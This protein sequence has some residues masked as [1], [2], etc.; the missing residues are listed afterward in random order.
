MKTV[1]CLLLAC[2]LCVSLGSGA[3]AGDGVPDTAL[4]LV[5]AMG[6]G[7]NLGNT[8][9]ACDA[10]RGRFSSFPADYEI[11][12]G[13]PVTTPEMLRGL[14]DAGFDTIRIPVAW[15]TNAT[16]LG[17]GDWTI[18]DAYMTRVAQVVGWALDAG[19]YVI[20][21]DHWDGGWWGMFGSDTA[22]TA[23][24]AREAYQ[25]MWQQIAARFRDADRH[26][27][28]ES[29]NEELGDR[30][31][32]DSAL[33]CDDSIRHLL[34]DAR[35][36]E[37]TNEINQLFVDTV[38]AAGGYNADRYLLIAGY[39]TNIAKTC[40]MRFKMPKDT[41]PD[42]LLISVHYYDPWSYC[43][44]TTASGA[45]RWGTRADMEYMKTTLGRMR[46]FSSQGYGVVIG[47]YGALPGSTGKQKDNAV[48]YHRLFL[49]LCEQYNYCGCLW[50]TSGFYNRRALRFHDEAMGALYLSARAEGDPAQAAA[51][52]G[53]D[54]DRLI[55]EAPE[56]FLENAIELDNT[57]CV[58]W[59]MWNSGDWQQSYSVGDT[60]TP[61]SVTPGLKPTDAVIDGPGDYTVA[62]DFT[63]TDRGYSNSTAFS[64]IG[65]RSGEALHPGWAVHIKSFKVNGQDYTL[66]GRPYTTSD[67]GRCTRVNIYNAWVSDIPADA[68]VLYGPNI[69]IKPVIIDLN[70]PVFSHIE[71]IEITFTY[72]EKK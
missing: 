36:Y 1:I 11:L 21:N 27:I 70:D 9:E 71:T 35:R 65:I 58:A 66:K 67:D 7:T 54:A 34:P 45:T 57:T 24:L 3:R 38:R 60:Y 12:W 44:A 62:L 32:E 51:N 50:D 37:L 47:E 63:G 42:R 40:D 17:E 26:L 25:G 52:A 43:G 56:T 69:G 10:N 16:R 4:E 20:L 30:F 55:A 2:C 31:D 33:Y 15:M 6:N 72:A 59:I 39:G 13:Q 23:A 8:F 18:D 68:R 61:D 5:R 49:D 48:T 46:Q 22:A 19:L 14:K 28:F 29:A 53:A 64:A 41:A